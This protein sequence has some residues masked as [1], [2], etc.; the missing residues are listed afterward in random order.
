[1]SR[2][3]PLAGSR[4]CPSTAAAIV[5]AQL[6]RYGD[7]ANGVDRALIAAFAGRPIDELE[8]IERQL[9]MFDALP[10]QDQRDMLAAVVERHPEARA[11][12]G[13][14][15]RLW[16]A[17]DVAGIEAE[18]TRGMLA[19]PELYE[20]LLAGRNRA[21]AARIVPMLD[22]GPRPLIAVGAAHVVGPHGLPALL[23]AQG[24]QVRR[25]K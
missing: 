19:D 22:A 25:I 11:D 6:V 7:S 20:A 3:S 2:A 10:E 1:M 24:F 9:A 8:G 16:L 18:L 5:L 4:H 13:A 17:G 23:E 12:P 14:L 21:W 15:A